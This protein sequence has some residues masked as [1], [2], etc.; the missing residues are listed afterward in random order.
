M[1]KS[2][3]YFFE[4]VFKSLEIVDEFHFKLIY[5]PTTRIKIDQNGMS[6]RFNKIRL[7]ST[8][9]PSFESGFMGCHPGF[10]S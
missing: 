10:F 3:L 4:R 7:I 6:S 8:Q 2:E 9:P 1:E 5:P